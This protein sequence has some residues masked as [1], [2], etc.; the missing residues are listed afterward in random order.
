MFP[1]A[2][3]KFKGFMV[4]EDGMLPIEHGIA[5]AV[6]AGV[7]AISLGSIG[8]DSSRIYGGAVLG[9]GPANTVTQQVTQGSDAKT[10]GTKKQAMPGPGLLAHLAAQDTDNSPK[11]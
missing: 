6:V 10:D 4:N 3:A 11:Y 7:I 5:A 9:A 1:T 2:L 8:P